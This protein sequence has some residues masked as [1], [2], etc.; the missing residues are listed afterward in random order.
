M[1]EKLRRQF[2]KFVDSFENETVT[3]PPQSSDSE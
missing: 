2:E 3:E 1:A